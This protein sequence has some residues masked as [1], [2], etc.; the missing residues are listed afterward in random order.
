MHHE[1]RQVYQLR[2]LGLALGFI[3]I[4]AVVYEHGASPVVWVVL[5]LYCFLWPHIACSTFFFE[6]PAAQDVSV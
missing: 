2:V 1:K 5:A 6:L 4:A 3:C